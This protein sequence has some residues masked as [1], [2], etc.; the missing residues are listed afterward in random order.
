[1]FR[2]PALRGG[3][4]LFISVITAKEEFSFFNHKLNNLGNA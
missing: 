4:N 3:L 2:P 1:M